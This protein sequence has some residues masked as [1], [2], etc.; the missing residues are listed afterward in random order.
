MEYFF[1][2]IQKWGRLGEF[3]TVMQ[4]WDCISGSQN[5]QEFS[6]PFDCLD[7]TIQKH[8]KSPQLLL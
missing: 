5:F 4:N 1:C 7:E 3:E 2:V 8:G 6:D